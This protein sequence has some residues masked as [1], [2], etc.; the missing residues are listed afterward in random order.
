MEV[1]YHHQSN[2][3]LRRLRNP[4]L[5]A[6]VEQVIKGLKAASTIRDVRGVRRMTSA[7]EHYRI[8][9]QRIPP[10]HH[11][12]RRDG[13][14]APVSAPGRNLPLFSVRVWRERRC[15]MG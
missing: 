13:H 7:G 10:G 3:D 11:N 8:T 6:Q 1:R 5:A 15:R 14:P 4:S 9:H 12:E 2:R